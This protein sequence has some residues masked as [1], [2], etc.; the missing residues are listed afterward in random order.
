MKSDQLFGELKKKYG[1]KLNFLDDKP[2]ETLDSSLKA[3]WHMA[4][5]NPMSAESV[6]ELPLPELTDLQVDLLNQLIAERISNKPLAHITGRQKFLGI[7]FICD[8]RALIPRKETEI[9]GRK[10][11]E[12]ALQLTQKDTNI[13]VVDVCCGAGNLGL[14]IAI[15]FPDAIVHATDISQ[16]AIDLTLENI[17]F[18]NLEQ[19]VTAVQGDLFSSV[20]NE[21]FISRTSLIVCNPP[22]ISTGK[23]KIMNPEILGKE[24]ALAFDGGMFGT[25]IIQKLIIEAPKFLITGG[26]LV[27]EV[28]AG[29]GEFI[30]KL[31][32]RSE[33]YQKVEPTFDKDGQIR[34]ISAMK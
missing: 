27:F 20:E 10:A 2:E 4:Y 26:W 30:L 18:L 22:Y 9:L 21:K 6:V 8:S 12:L 5:G 32:Q 31:C 25:K 33:L 3:L 17:S 13:V 15:N 23:V 14:A 16:D 1:D 11:I 7:D 24:P 19:R 28:G 34:V 29:Q